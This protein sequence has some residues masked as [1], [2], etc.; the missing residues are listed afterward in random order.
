MKILITTDWYVPAINGVVTSVLNLKRQL[1]ERG[2]QVRIL[3]LAQGENNRKWFCR[4]G[5]RRGDVW[6][7]SSCGVGKLYP[8][9]RVVMETGRQIISEIAAWKPDIVHS[10]C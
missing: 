10:Q 8:G 4:G 7:L 5:G 2:C 9:A 3:T 6:Y 1:E